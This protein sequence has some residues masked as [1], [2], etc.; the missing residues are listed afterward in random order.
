[1]HHEICTHSPLFCISQ[2]MRKRT[3]YHCAINSIHTAS[4]FA[5]SFIRKHKIQDVSVVTQ[6][7]NKALSLNAIGFVS[8]DLLYSS[9]RALKRHLQEKNANYNS[10]KKS[11]WLTSC[12]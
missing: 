11:L 5:Y 9:I 6:R 7:E 12:V 3:G 10:E 8:C 2:V 4:V 1:M